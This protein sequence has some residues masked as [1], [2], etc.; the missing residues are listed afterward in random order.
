MKNKILTIIIF[1]STLLAVNI[2]FTGCGNSNEK[3]AEEAVQNNVINEVNVEE[4]YFQVLD[5]QRS[6]ITRNGNEE[7]ISDYAKEII[8]DGNIDVSYAILNMDVDSKN[9]KEMVVL[10]ESSGDGK[11]LILN[12]EDD[13]LVYG[14]KKEYREMLNLKTDGTYK[15]SGGAA[16]TKII[17]STFNKDQIFDNI[18]AG[19]ENDK[20]TFNNNSLNSEEDFKKCM[21]EFDSKEAVKFT[22][23]K[24]II[25]ENDTST[26]NN[27][28]NNTNVNNSEI[29]KDIE[30]TFRVNFSEDIEQEIRKLYDFKVRKWKS[31]V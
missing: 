5:G 11:Y 2:T 30:G 14:F 27:Q 4:I 8:S 9:D 21:E 13:G 17:Q 31:N 22:L 10:L 25:I 16:D 24:E 12:Y 1:A 26:T 19:V 3:I 20:Y 6:Y 23:Y 15:I 29:S 18:V 7:Y 28:T